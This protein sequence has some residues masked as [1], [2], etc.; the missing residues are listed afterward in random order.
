MLKN[1]FIIPRAF[2]LE[3]NYKCLVSG[4]EEDVGQG[5]GLL[6]TQLYSNEETVVQVNYHPTFQI[7]EVARIII[8]DKSIS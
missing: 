5:E 2:Q 3:R 4:I 7:S 1:V 8:C 6:E